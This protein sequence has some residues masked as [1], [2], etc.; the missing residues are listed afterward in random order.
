MVEVFQVT[1]KQTR[2]GRYLMKLVRVMV[3][4]WMVGGIYQ[5]LF[6]EYDRVPS[7]GF[8]RISIQT[9]DESLNTINDLSDKYVYNDIEGL[10]VGERNKRLTGNLLLIDKMNYLEGQVLTEG[11]YQ[12]YVWAVDMKYKREG[13]LIEMGVY[14]ILGLLTVV[15]VFGGLILD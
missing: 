1:K 12:A 4:L 7:E 5:V 15:V 9:Y 13:Y 10:T 2:V 8:G 14:L 6:N 11:D 3:I